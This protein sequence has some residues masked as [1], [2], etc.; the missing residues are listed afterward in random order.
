MKTREQMA[1]F[2]RSFSVGQFDKSHSFAEDKKD[3][4]AGKIEN[5]IPNIML[6]K[7]CRKGIF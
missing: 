2:V 7:V 4:A 1:G 3:Q 6:V 5:M